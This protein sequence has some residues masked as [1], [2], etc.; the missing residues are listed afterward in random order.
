MN[1]ASMVVLISLVI[2]FIMAV[3]HLLKDKGGCA[4]CGKAGSCN[5]GC[6]GCDGCRGCGD[7]NVAFHY[8]PPEKKGREQGSQELKKAAADKN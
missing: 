3:R 8:F 5:S 1:L 2:L 6:G 7:K 4:G